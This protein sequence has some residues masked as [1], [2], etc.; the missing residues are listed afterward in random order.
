MKTYKPTKLSKEAIIALLLTGTTLL[1]SCSSS[2]RSSETDS[3]KTTSTKKPI[4]TSDSLNPTINSIK[5]IQPNYKF[6][7]WDGE[8]YLTIDEDSL[9]KIID[10]AMRDA[11]DFYLGIGSYNMN[12][13]DN[14]NRLS[15]KENFYTTWMNNEFFMARA[16]QEGSP[17]FMVNYRAGLDS[18]INKDP[19]G[20]MQINPKST[21]DTLMQY[22]SYIYGKNID[23]NSLK[24]F[25][26]DKDVANVEKS[27]QAQENITETV[28]NNVYLSICYD[29]YQAKC[30][31][32]GHTDYFAPYG[33]YDES[34]RHHATIA[35]YY[36]SLDDIVSSLIAGKFYETY[37]PTVY[38]QNILKFQDEFQTKN[39]ADYYYNQQPQN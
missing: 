13:D 32:P 37:Y 28:Y 2:N 36:Y 30:L 21:K 25:P 27:K 11:Q 26:S 24:V 8:L 20:I 6:K 18:D 31:N 38:V 3:N 10:L 14:L 15:G 19:C 1:A 16:K 12:L 22:Y 9:S 7:R 33:G 23:L 5:D 17:I 35:S 4:S 29:I 34:I 39:L